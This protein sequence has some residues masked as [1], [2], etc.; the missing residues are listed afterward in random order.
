[1][2]PDRRPRHVVVGGVV[3]RD[4]V[5]V[6]ADERAVAGELRALLARRRRDSARGGWVSGSRP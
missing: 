6:S 2:T 1:L 5:L 3:V 4:G